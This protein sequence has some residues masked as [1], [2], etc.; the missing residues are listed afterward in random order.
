MKVGLNTAISFRAENAQTGVNNT[1]NQ[2]Q[3]VTTGAVKQDSFVSQNN[4]IEQKPKKKAG[5]RIADFWKFLTVTNQMTA[6][7]LKGIGYGAVTSVAFLGGAWVFRALP[8]AFT[9][10]GPSLWNVIKH[11]LEHSGKAGKV[12]AGIAGASVLGYHVVA[13]KLEANQKTAVI[14]H[15]LK[16][17]HRG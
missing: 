13:G 7:V 12:I 8:K 10:G 2:T 16:V 9:K 4:E 15:K 5:E 3:N 6:S 1:A 17:G 11:P 14:D